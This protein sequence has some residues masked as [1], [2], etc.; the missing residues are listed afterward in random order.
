MIL[1]LTALVLGFLLDLL[2]GDPHWLPHPIRLIGWL[3]AKL[4][5][6]TRRLFPRTPKGEFAAGVLM[7]LLV[8]TVSAGVPLGILALCSLAGDWL[9][10]I[11]ETIMAYQILAAKSLK[12]ESMKVYSQLKQGDLPEMCIRDSLQRRHPGGRALARRVKQRPA[13]FPSTAG[14]TGKRP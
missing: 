9:V 2:L 6:L 5:G 3:I 4:E 13:V 7:C 12:V 14:F 10:L 8:L 1:S 11:A